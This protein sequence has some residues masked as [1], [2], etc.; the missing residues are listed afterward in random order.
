MI[1]VTDAKSRV[2]PGNASA[3]TTLE[4]LVVAVVAGSMI[5]LPIVFTEAFPLTSTPMFARPL[6]RRHYYTLT[7]ANGI[8]LNNDQY[9]IRSRVNWYLE[10][11]YAV[12]YPYNVVKSPEDLPEVSQLCRHVQARGIEEQ[13]NFPLILTC[14]VW[15]PIDDQRV[16]AIDTISWKID[17]DSWAEMA[18]R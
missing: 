4:K 10:D 12:K 5:V 15:G 14:E 18:I 1:N 16:S 11:F 13:A 8:T 6:E 2:M 17:T 3:P 9:G 7:D